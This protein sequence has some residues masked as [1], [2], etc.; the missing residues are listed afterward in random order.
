MGIRSCPILIEF[1][2]TLE[3]V[4]CGKKKSNTRFH[5]EVAWASEEEC[6]EIVERAW[7][8]QV[9]ENLDLLVKKS[10]RRGMVLDKWN[11][12]KQNALNKEI[13]T[14]KKQL[15]ELSSATDEEGWKKWK[16]VERELNELLLKEEK[17]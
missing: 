5:F 1:A 17:L 14:R 16:G 11:K 10:A 4:E 9:I 2:T 13:K 6:R 12:D 15:K 8:N 7:N 3:G